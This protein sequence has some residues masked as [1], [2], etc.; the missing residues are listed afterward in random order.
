MVSAIASPL[1]L[2]DIPNKEWYTLREYDYIMQDENQA[3]NGLEQTS[4]E[5]Q[6]NI[7]LHS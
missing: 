4:K 5:Q 2:D 7:P 6:S 1:Y 3:T